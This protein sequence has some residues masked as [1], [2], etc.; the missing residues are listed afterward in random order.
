L[1][2]LSKNAKFSKFQAALQ[3]GLTRGETI[4]WEKPVIL[5]KIFKMLQ[6]F[7][8]FHILMLDQG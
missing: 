7:Q 3:N 8:N 5:P 4:P 1:H 6:N 2:A